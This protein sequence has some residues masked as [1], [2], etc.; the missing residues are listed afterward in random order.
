MGPPF[1]FVAFAAVARGLGRFG[2]CLPC[3][4]ACQGARFLCK[5]RSQP[6]GKPVRGAT[7]CATRPSQSTPPNPP[8]PASKPPKPPKPETANVTLAFSY[9]V[10]LSLLAAALELRPAAG[11]DGSPAAPLASKLQVL[12]CAEPEVL[13]LG[14]TAA[15]QPGAGPGPRRWGVGSGFGLG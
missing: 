12:P 10:D 11:A 5:P 15:A 7:A 9:P 4:S 13:P 2:A 8:Q 3:R 1:S 6:A 14:V